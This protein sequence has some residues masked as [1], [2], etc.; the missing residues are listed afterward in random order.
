MRRHTTTGVICTIEDVVTSPTE[1]S[2]TLVAVVTLTSHGSGGYDSP[3]DYDEAEARCAVRG[4][5]TDEGEADARWRD[6]WDGPDDIDPEQEAE[7]LMEKH[8]ARHP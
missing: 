5:W 3:D 6:V 4:E 8:H 1:W 7:R 2:C